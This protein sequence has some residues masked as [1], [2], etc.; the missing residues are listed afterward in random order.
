L[1]SCDSDVVFLKPFDCGSLWDRG[2]LRFFRR[3]DA[4]RR[5]DLAEQRL[6]SG[7]AGLALGLPREPV[8]ETDYIATAIAW[9]RDCVLNMCRRIEAVHDREWIEVVATTRAFSE[10]MLYGRFVDDMLGTRLHS[11]T[12]I[13]LCRVYW[14][15]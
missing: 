8:S 13:E 2:N 15:G 3:P 6:W 10:C 11:P 1:F 9:R 5:P 7:N 4:L 14:N 12:E